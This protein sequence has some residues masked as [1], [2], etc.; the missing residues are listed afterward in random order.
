MFLLNSL[1]TLLYLIQISVSGLYKKRTNL[2]WNLRKFFV[3]RRNLI[4][5]VTFIVFNY[6]YFLNRKYLY[7]KHRKSMSIFNHR[8][9]KDIMY[10]S[11][12]LSTYKRLKSR[13]SIFKWWDFMKDR[14]TQFSY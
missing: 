12:I 9:A 13:N 4:S 14:F 8:P 3:K 1:G 2:T 10:P 11:K 5:G 7:R 6:R